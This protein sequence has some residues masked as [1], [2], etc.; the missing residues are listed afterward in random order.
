MSYWLI[1][2]PNKT[3]DDKEQQV[4]SNATKKYIDERT[5]SFSTNFGFNIPDLRVG[6]MDSLMSLSEEMSKIDQIVGSIAKKLERAFQESC[7]E[8]DE[9]SKEGDNNNIPELKVEN[10]SPLKYIQLFKWDVQRFSKRGNLKQMVE[11]ILKEAAKNDDELKK[12]QQEYNDVRQQYTAIERKETGTLLVKPLNNFV[13][14]GHIIETEHLTTL[15]IVVPR[16]KEEEF[17]DTYE[18]LEDLAAEREEARAREREEAEREKAEAAEEAAADAAER[19]A[20]HKPKGEKAKAEKP[21]EAAKPAPTAPKDDNDNLNLEDGVK[22]EEKK[23][24]KTKT[25]ANL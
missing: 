1:A 16:T 3:A 15:L 8:G 18:I 14:K 7:K 19:A 17:L 23:N 5:M 6:T 2:V 24:R 9:K 25:Q 11:N 4:K 20:K 21:T 13:K 10:Q 22:K 12:H